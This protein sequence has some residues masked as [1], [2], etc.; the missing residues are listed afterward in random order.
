MS[1][2]ETFLASARIEGEEIGSLYDQWLPQDVVRL[3]DD[4]T[5]V[6]FKDALSERQAVWYFDANRDY[7]GSHIEVVQRLQPDDVLA[8]V[9]PWFDSLSRTSL[10]A[11]PS[12]ARD[13]LALPLFLSTQLAAAWSVRMMADLQQIQTALVEQEREIT[14]VEGT[15][16]SARDLRRLLATRI[17]RETLVV[18]SPFSGLPLRSQISFVVDHRLIHRFYD[19]GLDCAFYLAWWEKQ[20]DA[21]PS[22]Y[23]PKANIIVSDENM[24]GML[25]SLV[26]GWYL[27]TPDHVSMI[28][29]AQAFEAR[30]YGLGKASALMAES[31]TPDATLPSAPD[32]ASADLISESWAF[33]HQHKSNGSIVPDPKK[34]P[35][36]A[37]GL[38]NRL[39]SIVKKK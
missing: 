10:A 19:E 11:M 14:R 15:A 20:I 16:L 4:V 22:F 25:P 12:P 26:L 23:C 37:G 38:F 34:D 33:L 18:L 24:A 2:A 31:H 29:G 21:P 30:D 9:S 17:G 6:T 7:C 28:M 36:P 39:R 35:R 3:A 5:C 1:G 32:A 27:S 8:T 13:S